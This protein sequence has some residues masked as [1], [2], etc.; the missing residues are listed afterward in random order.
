MAHIGNWNWNLVTDEVY[1][2]DEVYRIFG[3][4]PQEFGVTYDEF[5]SYIHPDDRDY[6]NNAVKKAL[7]GKPIN[8]DYRI[9]LA[10]GEERTVHAQGSYF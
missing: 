8:I 10:N 1:W 3:R 2:S 7:N 4:K 6:V 5:L 9:I